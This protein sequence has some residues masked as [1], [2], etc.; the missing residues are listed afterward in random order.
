MKDGTTKEKE[1]RCAKIV[2]LIMKQ[3]NEK[4]LIA[5]F[6]KTYGKEPTQNEL[7]QFRPYVEFTRR[8]NPKHEEE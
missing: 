7:D 8:W 3:M 6:K 5:L 1:S 2:I 4:R